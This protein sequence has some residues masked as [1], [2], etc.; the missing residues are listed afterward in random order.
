MRLER[1]HHIVLREKW[2]MMDFVHKVN[3]EIHFRKVYN[4]LQMGGYLLF[5]PL[6]KYGNAPNG[7]EMLYLRI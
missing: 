6:Q 2:I 5:I 3:N 4:F 7:F 1:R